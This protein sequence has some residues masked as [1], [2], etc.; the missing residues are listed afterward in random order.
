M[1]RPPKGMSQE[2]IEIGACVLDTQKG[3]HKRDSIIVKPKSST[4]S[5]FCNKLTSLTQ[6]DVDMGIDL[7]DAIN[8]LKKNFDSKN[9]FWCS[10]GIFDKR[11]MAKEAAIRQID[12]PFSDNYVDLQ[13]LFQNLMGDKE[14]MSVQGALSRFGKNFAGKQHRAMYDSYNT[15]RI[16]DECIKV[17]AKKETE[18]ELQ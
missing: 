3:L 10:W 18:N 13:K 8:I 9:L 2:I 14:Q 1:G 16:L 6:N 7:K 11:H 15:M 4:I 12:Y 17:F 5:K